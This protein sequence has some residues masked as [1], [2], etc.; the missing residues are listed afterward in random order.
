MVK[1]IL[2]TGS[3]GFIGS[4]LTPKLLNDDQILFAI[5]R[6]NKINKKKA[7]KVKKKFKNYH[8]IFFEKIDQLKNKLSKL[9]VDVVVNL[10]TKYLNKHNFKEMIEL[11]NS[12]ILFTTVVLEALPKK[13]L[14]KYINLNTMTLYKNSDEYEPLSLYAA[15]KKGFTDIIKFYQINFKQI[16]FYNISI[17]DTYGQNDKR[18]KII[19]TLIKNYKSNKV[20]TIISKKLKM[21]LLNVND[22]CS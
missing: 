3:S 19:P 4:Y 1:K 13:K 15:T 2:V 10:A 17:Y 14:K 20:T 8:P 6:N 22:I 5:L 12:N 11:I 21:N 18:M 16:K 7:I 9:K